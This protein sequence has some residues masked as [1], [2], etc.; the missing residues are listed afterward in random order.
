MTRP[1]EGVRILDFTQVFAGPLASYQ[2]SLL[3][4]DVIK[5][6]RQGGED[7]RS[8][9]RRADQIGHDT[10]PG[11]IS[12]N[13]NKRN[14]ALDLKDPAAIEIIK[15][16]VTDVDVV[17]E[18]FRP[19]VMDRLGI[20]YDDLKAINPQLI[21]CCVSGFGREGPMRDAP[22]YDG[23]I[24]AMSGIMSITG[25]E[26]MGPMRAGF[27]V[28]DATAGLTAAFG[29]ASAL[30]QRTHTGKGQLVD[31]AMYDS[32]LAVQ[33][34]GVADYTIAGTAHKPYGNR[35]ISGRPTADLFPVKDGYI[36]L[37]VNN[38]K[39]FKCLMSAIG[40]EELLDDPR[41]VDWGARLENEEALI[42]II[43][44]AFADA[45]AATWEARLSEAGAPCAQI[46]TIAEAVNHPQMAHRD[47]MQS[48]KGPNGP[49]KLATTGFRLAHGNASLDRGYPDL[50]EHA[51]EVLAEAGFS[52][53]EIADLRGRGII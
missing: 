7:M 23:K 6:E 41:F 36:L 8:T 37:A 49:V 38:E 31:V 48:T 21:Y 2:L 47:F 12:I 30:F 35:A 17:M 51:E 29:V 4:A 39:Q 22:S 26:E 32:A 40:R 18:N 44:E 19:G 3:G 43:N 25:F 20:G 45:D 28:C 27:A 33:S 42:A 10:A 34:P 14:I 50:G 46:Q 1:F 5:V 52:A 24:Q 9:P 15:R 13:A 16:L 53:D 11:W